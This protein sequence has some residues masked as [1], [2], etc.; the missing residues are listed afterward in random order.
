[1]IT[2]AIKILGL[3]TVVG[4]RTWGGVIG[5][6]DPFRLVD[7]TALTVPRFAIWLNGFGWGVENHGVDPD[8]E[9]LISPEDWAAGRDPQLETATRL[10]MEQLEARPAAQPPDYSGRPSRA[11]P[12][13][14]PR[15]S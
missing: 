14:P 7:G 12:A 4:A 11:R 13:L 8:T 6:G 1:M 9:V 5:I 15:S 10:A 2:A 3:G